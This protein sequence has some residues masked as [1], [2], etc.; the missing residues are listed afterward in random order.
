[1]NTILTTVDWN[2]EYDN[3][4]LENN[5]PPQYLYPDEQGRVELICNHFIKMGISKEMIDLNELQFQAVRKK[6]HTSF[7]V[8]W[9]TFSRPL[10]RLLYCLPSILSLNNILVVGCGWGVAMGFLAAGMENAG[11]S[12]TSKEKGT[13]PLIIGVDVDYEIINQ[14]NKN[15]RNL[16]LYKI[17]TYCLLG[18]F[19]NPFI[20]K[21]IK[22]DL[23]FLDVD[24]AETSLMQG[25]KIYNYIVEVIYPYIRYNGFLVTHDTRWASNQLGAFFAFVRNQHNFK[26]SSEIRL[27]IQGIEVSQK[28]SQANE[29]FKQTAQSLGA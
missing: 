21:D 1:M 16:S 28:I 20:G 4:H 5:F 12:L 15:I 7:Q 19:C 6:I 13:S 27:D 23:V 2:L 29:R 3:V 25:K 8:P 14:A 18:D 24:G 11:L 26:K 17:Q 9:T 10:E 22:F